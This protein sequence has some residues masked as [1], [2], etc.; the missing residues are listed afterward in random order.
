MEERQENNYILPEFSVVCS[1]FPAGVNIKQS[2]QLK[3]WMNLCSVAGESVK[4]ESQTGGVR[5]RSPGFEKS[6]YLFIFF[7]ETRKIF[8][9]YC[10]VKWEIWESTIL[11]FC[12][13]INLQNVIK[14]REKNTILFAKLASTSQLEKLHNLETPVIE[15][16]YKNL[17]YP[18][19]S[20]ILIYIIFISFY[21]LYTL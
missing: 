14:I 8:Y 16:I 17:T 21:F 6:F 1:L 12:Q 20:L 9:L 4:V 11:S 3:E 2:G 13:I 15:N 10:Y 7:C 5:C 18:Q 19:V